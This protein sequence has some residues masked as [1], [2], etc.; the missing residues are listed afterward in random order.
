MNPARTLRCLC[1]ILL[2]ACTQPRPVPETVPQVGRIHHSDPVFVQADPAS[3]K[4][5][6]ADAD[7]G[8]GNLCHPGHR[9]CFSVY[10]TPRMLNISFSQPVDMS[11][12]RPVNVYFPFDS[13]ELLPEAQHWLDYNLR[14][15][16]TRRIKRLIIEAHCDARG[17]VEYN[18]ALSLRR[19]EA[20]RKYLEAAGL[21]VP[22]EVRGLGK[23]EPIKPGLTEADY[24]WNR[25]A[26]FRFE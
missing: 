22:I 6:E 7:C 12:C 10:P 23:S 8:V 14:C 15:F 16:Q 25:R 20:V 19:G 1:A 26:E 24:A 17:D 13:H 3:S 2:C 5:C 18:K 11:Q 9:V 21:K 4:S